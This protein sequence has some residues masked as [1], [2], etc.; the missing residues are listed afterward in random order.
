MYIK[1]LILLYKPIFLGDDIEEGIIWKIMIKKAIIM[2]KK[3]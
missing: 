3:E 1:Y 2:L